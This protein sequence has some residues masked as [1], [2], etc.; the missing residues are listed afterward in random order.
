VLFKCFFEDL[1]AHAITSTKFYL[2]FLT[3][4]K[5]LLRL[6]VIMPLLEK[7]HSLIKF[8]QMFNMFVCDFIA[9]VE[10]CEMDV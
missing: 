3:N 2:C 7:I 1:D 8:A 5:T 6:N 4:A 9:I 10:I